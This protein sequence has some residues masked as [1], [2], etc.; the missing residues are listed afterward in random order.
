MDIKY[1]NADDALSRLN[2]NKRLYIMLLKKFNGGDL[3]NELKEAIKENRTDDGILK[4]HTIKGLA[5]NLSLPDLRAEAEKVEKAL[6]TGETGVSIS[7]IT[8]STENTVIAVQEY[9]KENS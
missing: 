9:L 7:D 3:L 5:A 6:K 4:A 2:N 8:A 1:I